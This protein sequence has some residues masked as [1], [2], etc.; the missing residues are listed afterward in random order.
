VSG[1]PLLDLREIGTG[2]VEA[3]LRQAGDVLAVH[4]GHDSKNTPADPLAPGGLPRDDP[5]SAFARFRR[6][7]VSEILTAFGT[8][9]DAH[10]AVAEQG[11]VAVD[12]YDGCLIYD[13]SQRQMRLC[14]LDS[15]RPGPY[16]LDQDRQYGSTRFLAPEEFLRGALIDERTTVFTLGRTAFVL[17]GAPT[18]GPIP[19]SPSAS[20]RSASPGSS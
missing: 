2:D 4:R 9:L 18:G 19:K 14:D 12:F 16:I 17:P 15:Y 10:R 1:H 3:F 7:P 13:F 11:V 5:R 20:T 8:V 6:L